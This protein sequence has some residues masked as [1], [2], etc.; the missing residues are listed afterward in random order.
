MPQ[1]AE[2][3]IYNSRQIN[4]ALLFLFQNEIKVFKC[5]D[6]QATKNDMIQSNYFNQ[7]LDFGEGYLSVHPKYCI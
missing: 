1:V 7:N 5:A 4:V 2:F 6:I 3:S